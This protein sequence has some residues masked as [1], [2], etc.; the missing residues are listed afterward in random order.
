VTL[1]DEKKILT[2]KDKSTLMDVICHEFNVDRSS[3]LVLQSWSRKYMDWVD[4]CDCTQ[5]PDSAKL[6]VLVKRT[7]RCDHQFSGVA[8]RNLFRELY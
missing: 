2:V 8:C 7:W 1:Q 6:L 3:S 5:L 4:V